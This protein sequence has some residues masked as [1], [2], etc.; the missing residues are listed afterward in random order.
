MYVHT[1]KKKKTNWKTFKPER[2]K[3][4]KKK[5]TEQV[6]IFTLSLLSSFPIFFPI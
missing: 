5:K 1:Y 4:K 3:Q 2:Q 6:L